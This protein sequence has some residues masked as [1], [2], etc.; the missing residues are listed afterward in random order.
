MIWVGCSYVDS[1]DVAMLH[2]WFGY[3]CGRD[4]FNFVVILIL[5]LWLWLS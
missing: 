2:G 1:L 5:L 4:Y 3:D